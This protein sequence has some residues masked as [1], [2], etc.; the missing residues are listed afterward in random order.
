[1][2]VVAV[3]ESAGRNKNRPA[4]LGCRLVNLRAAHQIGKRGL[5]CL[6]LCRIFLLL[7][8]IP[9]LFRARCLVRLAGAQRRRQQQGA[10]RR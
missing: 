1:M 6:L 5:G 2:S 3:T 7:L 10:A 8:S 4:P 9:L